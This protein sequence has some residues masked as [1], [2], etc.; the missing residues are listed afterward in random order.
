MS[1]AESNALGDGISAHSDV[2]EPVVSE[3]VDEYLCF[4]Q[5]PRRRP[6]AM[7]GGEYARSGQGCWPGCSHAPLTAASIDNGGRW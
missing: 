5:A 6:R 7:S 2:V 4:G 3:A 1:L